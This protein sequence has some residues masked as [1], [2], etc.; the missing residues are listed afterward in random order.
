[1][2]TSHGQHTASTAAWVVDGES[3]A[4]DKQLLLLAAHSQADQELYDFS[5]CIILTSLGIRGLLRTTDDN[6]KDGTHH[7]IAHL[8]WMQ[9][10]LLDKLLDNGKKLVASVQTGIYLRQIHRIAVSILV[11]KV[12]KNILHIIRKSLDICLEGITDLV[13]RVK[14]FLQ[15][16]P[17]HIEECKA[18]L[19]H[20][21]QEFVLSFFL[22][23]F[24]VQFFEDNLIFI[25]EDTIQT[26]K[27]GERQNHVLHLRIIIGVTDHFLNVPYHVS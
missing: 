2:L 21:R 19:L 23:F 4:R 14:E 16:E 20:Q 3:L 27:Q 11:Y 10:S 15:R 25:F 22:I 8:T 13:W 26:T 6:L 12:G 18:I 5:W 7:G 17:R 9:V 24:F 1:M